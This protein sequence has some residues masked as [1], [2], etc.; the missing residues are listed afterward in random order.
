MD[1]TLATLQPPIMGLF[2]GYYRTPASLRDQG[3]NRQL[4]EDSAVA[5]RAL[6]R[7]LSERPFVAGREFSMAD[8][9]AGTLMFRYFEMGIATPTAPA[10]QA[11]RTRLAERAP[12]REHVMRAFGE[13][14]GRLA[15]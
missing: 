11:W 1:W 3:R 10:V 8:I 13:L 7:W 4:E 5:V 2:W 9:P 14:F 15:Y 6:D 12:Y